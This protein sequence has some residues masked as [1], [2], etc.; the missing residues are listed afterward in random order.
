MSNPFGPKFAAQLPFKIQ[1]LGRDVTL[2]RSQDN[3]LSAE[4]SPYGGAGSILT[5]FQQWQSRRTI[6]STSSAEREN[7]QQMERR[8]LHPDTIKMFLKFYFS[9]PV[10]PRLFVFKPGK[11]FLDYPVR[12]MALDEAILSWDAVA[13]WKKKSETKTHFSF[14]CAGYRN[15]LSVFELEHVVKNPQ[16]FPLCMCNSSVNELS[17]CCSGHARA[18]SKTLFTYYPFFPQEGM[19]ELAFT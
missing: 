8:L 19:P 17:A 13:N 9:K 7:Y 10:F 2:L 14:S 18:G 3:K 12:A 1:V 4:V 16:G 15:N 6:S 11:G 5:A